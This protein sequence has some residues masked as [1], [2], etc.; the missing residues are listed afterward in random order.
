MSILAGLP[1]NT[2]KLMAKHVKPA[3]L[4]WDAGFLFLFK[5]SNYYYVINFLIY[6]KTY[7]DMLNEF[8]SNFVDNTS[9]NP[10]IFPLPE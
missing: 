4:C 2:S 5:R 10:I 3:S 8:A 6:F 1:S 7:K 9:F